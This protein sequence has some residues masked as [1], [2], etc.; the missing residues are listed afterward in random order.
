MTG[1]TLI[2][3]TGGR[4]ESL[5]RCRDYV[6]RFENP[7]DLPIQWIVV[8]DVTVSH[9]VH[10]RKLISCSTHMDVLHP[11]HMWHPGENT[12]ARNLLVAIP[13]VRHDAIMFIEDDD[14]YKPDYMRRQLERLEKNEL[15]GEGESRYYHL[16]SS[17]WR[18]ITNTAHAS[19]CQT[20][21]HYTMLPSLALICRANH[22]FVDFRLWQVKTLTPNLI[23]YGE[24]HVIGIKGLPGRTGIGIGHR[25][26]QGA[27]WHHDP[28]HET[29]RKWLGS[30]ADLYIGSKT[31]PEAVQPVA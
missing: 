23:N 13:H 31:L 3:C 25:P 26:D 17:R 9:S 24:P 18:I 6:L 20:A 15:V 14:C 8:D 21:M 29:L 7:D 4:P 30:D 16:P 11:T 12:L 22:D 2:T 28:Y 10:D 5:A 1:V 19:L 27:G